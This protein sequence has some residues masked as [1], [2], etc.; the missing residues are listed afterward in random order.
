[1]IAFI[2][3]TVPVLDIR[4][5]GEITYMLVR[6][7]ELRRALAARLPGQPPALMRGHGAVVVASDLPIAVA[8]SIYL[9]IN[10]KLQAQAMTLSGDVTYLDR[11]EARLATIAQDY[12]RA[13]ELWKR[14]AMAT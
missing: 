11:E 9:E 5:T 10:A 14:K 3:Y 8:R 1:M 6:S 2:A 7:P 12:R 13:W 4:K